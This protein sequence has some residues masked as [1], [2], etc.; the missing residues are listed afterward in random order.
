MQE[1]PTKLR[2]TVIQQCLWSAEFTIWQGAIYAKKSDVYNTLGCLTRAINRLVTTL[3]AINEIYQ[4][5]DKNALNILAHMSKVPVHLQ[6]KI[7][8]ILC[9]EIDTLSDQVNALRKIFEE[10]VHLADGLYKPYYEL[11]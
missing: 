4:M 11:S 2:N 6:D 1:Y 5:G 8:A 7:N 10:T 3:F 9:C